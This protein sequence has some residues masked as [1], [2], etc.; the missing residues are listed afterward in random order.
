MH[1]SVMLKIVGANWWRH[2]HICLQGQ[3][4]P[5]SAGPRLVQHP[6]SGFV[7]AI[8]CLVLNGY[9]I[10]A[11]FCQNPGGMQLDLTGQTGVAG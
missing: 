5:T 6:L 2:Q 11:T 4:V 3:H 1:G 9:M 10:L 8:K 7:P